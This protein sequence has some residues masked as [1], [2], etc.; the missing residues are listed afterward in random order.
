[1]KQIL[2]FLLFWTMIPPLFAGSLR[3]NPISVGDGLSHSTVYSM[4]QDQQGFMWIGTQDGLNKYDGYGFTIYRYDPLDSTSLASSN[5]SSLT[6]TTDGMIW[7]GS[8]GAGLVEFDPYREVSRAYRHDPND[9]AS[10]SNNRA[11]VVFTDRNGTIWVGTAGGG[12]N[13]FQRDSGTFVRYLHDPA[14]SLSLSHNRIW[15]IDEDPAGNLWIGTDDGL[16]RFD[17]QTET[18][19][20]FKHDPAQPQSLSHSRIRTLKVVSE[21]EIWVGTQA[22]LNRFNPL[23]GIATH[24]RH[25]PDDPN[26]LSG[27]VITALYP[28]HASGTVWVGT[29]NN[30]LNRLDPQTGRVSRY[31]NDPR[32]PHS[33]SHNNVRAI[34]EDRAGMFWVATRRGGVNTFRLVPERFQTW[35]HDPLNP[36]SLSDDIIWSIY[37]DRE[38]ILWIGTGDGGLNRWDRKHQQFTHYQHDPADPTTLNQNDVRAIFEDRFGALWIGT[39]DG[40]LN[41][42]DR[43]RGTF[44]HYEPNPDQP[45]SLSN[46]DVT[47]IYEDQ[48]GLLWIGTDG[49]GLNRWDRAT[50]TFIHYRHDPRN[51]H[52]LSDD[53]VWLIYETMSGDLWIGTGDG[54]NRLD[55]ETDTFEVFHQRQ[56][57]PQ[58]SPLYLINDNIRAMYE[59]P[60]GVLWI[61]TS[62]GGLH[63]W[64]RTR[65]KTQYY[66]TNDGLPSN[67]INSILPDENGNLWLST[68]Q[69]LSQFDPLAESFRNFDVHDGLQSNVFN[70]GAG[71]KTRQGTLFFGGIHGLNE[72]DAKNI[73]NNSYIPPVVIT[74]I[75]RFDQELP[76]E[77]PLP[78]A[79][80]IRLPF[81]HNFFSLE[82]AGLNFI[83]SAKN[84]YVYRLEGFDVN[85][86]RAG[87]RRYANYTNVPP[88][89]YHFRVRAANNDGVWNTEGASLTI[90]IDPPFWQ[91]WWFYYLEGIVGI[92]VLSLVI[93]SVS[94]YTQNRFENNRRS[95]ELSYARQVQFSMLPKSDLYH[96]TVE[97]VGKMITATEVGGDYYDFIELEDDQ[98]CLALGDAAGH[99]AASGLLVG[100]TKVSVIQAIKT[101]KRHITLEHFMEQFNAA[102]KASNLQRGMCM[103]LLLAVI[104]TRHRRLKVASSGMPYPYYYRKAEDRLLPLTIKGPPLGLLTNIQ[105]QSR[106]ILLEPGDFVIFLTDGFMER[107]N[108]QGHIWTHE[109]VEKALHHI[110]RGETSAANVAQRLVDACN[111]FANGREPEDDLTAVVLYVKS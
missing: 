80:Q 38:G 70:P 99:G 93:W 5:I 13:R 25:Q 98:Y 84:R 69:G 23:S 47:C 9:P 41:R 51:P 100:M 44:T 40:G 14:D 64:D 18:F 106:T 92:M 7:I 101:R 45:G 95:Q 8:W 24:Y 58:P 43:Q 30:G 35:Q 46:K 12:L 26:S 6:Q 81:H 60:D 42:L 20:T 94:R 32:D 105:V 103:S 83:Q 10:L 61:G 57:T 22:G 96:E 102:L 107:L 15:S 89:T 111:Q 55:R 87:T 29:T 50:N 82:F 54:L 73:H 33:L 68:N 86:V 110:C 71:L 36:N 34:Y 37:E 65:Q 3:F 11:Q 79:N 66:T 27:D 48:F 75:K 28:H 97:V 63:Q 76:V 62:G 67:V 49:G 109:A 39:D 1:M 56:E 72:F 53:L 85:W 91:T 31:Q 19:Q 108:L 21:T 59:A 52:S 88:G 17:P 90:L 104:D 77:P 16:N 2:V 78:L 4:W 74:S